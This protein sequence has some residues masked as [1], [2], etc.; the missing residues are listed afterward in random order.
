M[1]AND[2]CCREEENVLL[3]CTSFMHIKMQ[4]EHTLVKLACEH[5]G[6]GR[7]LLTQRGKAYV[8]ALDLA[9]V[10]TVNDHRHSNHFWSVFTERAVASRVVPAF[11]RHTF[12]QK[13]YA[14]CVVGRYTRLATGHSFASV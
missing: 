11:T 6:G 10:H 8:G 5:D 7:L 4:S 13:Q 9:L 3:Y 2:M 14:E 1:H 12:L